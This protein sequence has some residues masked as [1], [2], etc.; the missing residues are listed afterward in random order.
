MSGFG[1]RTA[2]VEDFGESARSPFDS[3]LESN[4]TFNHTDNYLQM[5][6]R[7]GYVLQ[8]KELTEMQTILR[9]QI[10]VLAESDPLGYG[11]PDANEDKLDTSDELYFRYSSEDTDG[12]DSTENVYNALPIDAKRIFDLQDWS[13]LSGS[14]ENFDPQNEYVK[15]YLEDYRRLHFGPNGLPIQCLFR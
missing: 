15:N 11:E 3:I 5:G 8:A 13:G 2:Y 14:G 6:I 1:T 10:R 4:D 12:N 9:N 7:P